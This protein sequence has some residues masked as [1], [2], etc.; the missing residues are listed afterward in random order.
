MTRYFREEKIRFRRPCKDCEE[1]FRP[2]GDYS[3]FCDNCLK[4]R[5]SYRKVTTKKG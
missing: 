2:S 5:L 1:L 3:E 4:V